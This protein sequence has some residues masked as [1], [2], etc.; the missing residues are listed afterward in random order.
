VNASAARDGAM[1]FQRFSG[2]PRIIGPANG[3]HPMIKSQTELREALQELENELPRMMLLNDEESFMQV[4]L[5]QAR[6]IE[7]CSGPDD[8]RHVHR[9]IARILASRDL[10]TSKAAMYA[11]DNPEAAMAF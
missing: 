4:F 6:A 9:R 2:F 3:G 8:A 5:G 1:S 10:I 7:D 11:N